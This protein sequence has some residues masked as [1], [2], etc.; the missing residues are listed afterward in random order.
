MNGYHAAAEP[1]AASLSQAILDTIKKQ[2]EFFATGATKNVG[3]RQGMIKQLCDCVIQNAEKISAAQEED[4]VRPSSFVGAAGMM[5][6]AMYFYLGNVPKWSAPVDLEDTM[7]AERRGGV[8][9]DWKCVP[10]PK[11]KILNI[12]PWNAPVLL[13]I[14]PC[15]GALAAGNT[16]VIKPPDAAPATSKL[17]AELIA[18]TMPPEAVFVVQGGPET[19]S[20]L[21]DLGFDHIMFTGGTS[22]GKIVMQRAARYLTPVTLE[23]GG[24]NPVFIDV[25]DDATCEAAVKEMVGTKMY[26]AGEF[27]QCHDIVYVLD[28]MYD[29]F[30]KMMEGG[31][32][33]LGEKRMVRIIHKKHYE[34]VKKMLTEHN[35][36]SIPAPPACDDSNLLLPVTMVVDAQPEDLIMQDEIFGPMW[37]IMKVASITEAIKKANSLPTGKPLVSYFYGQ[38]EANK[39]LWQ[40]GTSSGCLAFNAGPMRMQSNFNA[41]VHGVGNSGLGGASIWGK[42][43]FDTFSHHKHVV[44][45]KNGA[46]AGSIWGPGPIPG[47][48]I[49]KQLEAATPE[50]SLT[51][52]VSKG[53]AP[54]ARPAV[55][56]ELRPVVRPGINSGRDLSSNQQ[57]QLSANCKDSCKDRCDLL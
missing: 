50:A 36:K 20:A 14:L 29:K 53:V 52:D 49:A 35:G 48:P 22:I 5:T 11:G 15:L 30:M 23:L 24:K 19:C 27:C 42:H 18:A 7:P 37:V 12:A 3:W 2:D 8:E 39:D 26:F 13:S 54:E 21:I 56:P 32:E 1:V 46:F 31:I 51:N 25:M 44:R 28:S 55:A 17:L 33:A 4:G 57:P 6:G 43:V 34:R 38:D 41:A 9:C 40:N 16:C 45:P 10:E 47:K